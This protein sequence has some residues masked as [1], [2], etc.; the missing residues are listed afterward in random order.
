MSDTVTPVA[1][2][3]VLPRW[4]KKVSSRMSDLFARH[5]ADGPVCHVGS[6]INKEGAVQAD[7]D[8]WR[9]NFSKLANTEFVGIDIFAGVNVDVVADLCDPDFAKKHPKLQRR[10]GLVVCRALLEHVKNPIIA[11]RNIE[12]LVRE[13]GHLYV[14]GPWVWGYH[15]YPNDYWRLSFA[16]FGVL[17][18]N[19]DWKQWYYSGSIGNIGLEIDD[20]A[21]ERKL[22][23]QST[24]TGPA[25]LIS[26][27][28]LPYLNV[29]A[30]GVF[31]K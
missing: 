22:F 15:P 1:E 29:E 13:G 7:A 4:V 14:G 12:G 23:G 10:F 3:V 6:L 20:I 24:V 8:K 26:D 2:P 25:S 18:P 21:R 9:S 11:A 27:R 31:S 16:A 17:F 28:A 5:G 30:I 19:V